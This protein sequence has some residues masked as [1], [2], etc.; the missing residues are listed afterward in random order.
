M[1][2]SSVMAACADGLTLN[3][4]PYCR[5]Y[6]LVNQVSIGPDN[7]LS[8]IRRQ[9]IIETKAGL[10]SI[11]PLGTNFSEILVKNWFLFHWKECLWKCCLQNGGHLVQGKMS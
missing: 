11:G 4:S 5:I 3:S 9:A 7:D 8:P 2:N 1:S 10:L 6:A